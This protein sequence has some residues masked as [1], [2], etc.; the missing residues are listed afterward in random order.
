MIGISF[1]L[2]LGPGAAGGALSPALCA[3][4]SIARELGT[5]QGERDSNNTHPGARARGH[6]PGE[7]R[8]VV[9]GRS[10]RNDRGECSFIA[11][12][13]AFVPATT[14]I[15]ERAQRRNC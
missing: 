8:P 9:P 11:A 10:P 4:Y 13:Y 12:L 2:R 1:H 7:P 6:S 3:S 14:I 5:T 15:P